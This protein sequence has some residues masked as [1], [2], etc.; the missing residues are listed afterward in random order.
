MKTFKQFV[1]EDVD[2]HSVIPDGD[3]DISDVAIR[4]NLNT[5]LRRVCA[6]KYS[7]PYHALERIRQQL[8]YFSI[9]LPKY[10]F[11]D[12]EFGETAFEIH[13]FGGP[14]GMDNRGKFH[15]EPLEA[16]AM[17]L[18]FSWE[19][20]ENGWFVVDSELMDEPELEQVLDDEEEYA[21]D[22]DSMD[23]HRPADR[24]GLGEEKINWD[25][26]VYK[27]PH[28]KKDATFVIAKR[29]S[30][31]TRGQDGFMMYLLDK[32]GTIIDKF[33]SHPSLEG[34][35][36]WGK[37]RGYVN[38]ENIQELSPGTLKQ[39]RKAAAG[40][41]GAL[42]RDSMLN[43]D[44]SKKSKDK[45]EKRAK[46]IDKATKKIMGEAEGDYVWIIQGRGKAA[47]QKRVP[48]VSVDKWLKKGWKL[49]EERVDE[50]N[51]AG[52]SPS[53]NVIDKR[54]GPRRQ[55]VVA[56]TQQRVN[57]AAKGNIVMHT[58]NRA[59]KANPGAPKRNL[60]EED[61]QEL[62]SKTLRSYRNKAY[63]DHTDTTD[64]ANQATVRAMTS[65]TDAEASKHDA[66]A[67]KL[68]KRLAKRVSGIRM[69]NKKLK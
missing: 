29:N 1:K 32:G 31:K 67:Q 11:T 48:K 53:K 37:N 5:M 41:M 24:V 54:F 9:N 12:S 26:V 44:T 60:G 20:D 59:A 64:K 45:W 8:A 58:P 13:Q 3:K 19:L 39:Y 23:A 2:I 35:K 34:A 62:S 61:I 18:Y 51:L 50:L 16:K 15:K 57:N 17:F 46:G 25:D 65:K 21:E 68:D 56:K 66:T 52:V 27:N 22:D 30:Q 40:T 14:I 36:K 38:E 10:V 42:A 47:D 49:N 4:S 55:N 69:V 33:G 43:R 6:H 7:S 28:A 63:A